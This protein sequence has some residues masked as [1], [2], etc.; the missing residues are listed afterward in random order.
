MPSIEMPDGRIKIAIADTPELAKMLQPGSGATGGEIRL[1]GELEDL[2]GTG[3]L[4]LD[5]LRRRPQYFDGRFLTGA[6]LTRDQDYIR[7]RQADIARAGGSGVISG[8]N[9]DERGSISGDVL[10][11]SAGHGITREGDLVM[12]ATT[13][14]IPLMDL[15]VSRQLDMAMGL[16]IDPRIPLSS[17]S[18]IFVLGLRAIEF[19]AN[20]IAAYPRTL[21]GQARIEDGDII[22]A[23]AVTIIPYPDLNGAATLTDARRSIAR[24]IFGGNGGRGLPQNILPLALLALDRGTVHWIDTAMVRR[25]LTADSGI[26]VSLG[27]RPRSLAEAHVNQHRAHVQD[28]LF[29]LQSRNTA[30]VFPASQFFSLLP[31]AG[32]LPAATVRPEA[33]GLQQVYFPPSVDVD[34]AFVPSDE[35]AA[36]VEESLSLPPID[37]D[38]APEDLDATGIVILLPVNR[39]RYQRFA[40][41]LKGDTSI[42]ASGDASLVRK[43]A[44]VD[45]IDAMRLRQLKKL[46]TTERN[47]E[48]ADNKAD[49]EMRVKAWHD[50]FAEAIDNLPGGNDGAPLLWYV[51]RRSIAYRSNVEGLAIEVSGDDVR[52]VLNVQNRMEVLNLKKALDGIAT[53]ST[54]QASAAVSA[55][56]GSGK[57]AGSN[58]LTAAIV[59]DLGKV[60][61][62]KTEEIVEK[63]EEIKEAEPTSEPS[64]GTGGRTGGGISG[65][66]F[67]PDDIRKRPDLMRE[68]VDIDRLR[69][70][71]RRILA[72]KAA[73]RNTAEREDTKLGLNEAEVRN[74]ASDFTDPKVGEG[75]IAFENVLGKEAPDTKGVTFIAESGLALVIDNAMANTKIEDRK[76]VATEINDAVKKKDSVAIH[77][78]VNRTGRFG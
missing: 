12:L 22:E 11:I 52:T 42:S 32:Q 24:Q 10:T 15:P 63:F 26:Q 40:A 78:I 37:L 38:S 60:S 43:S 46:E 31:P 4:V 16:S 54:P 57:I 8:L 5:G 27:G 67:R 35:I 33:E 68:P 9:L 19:T 14:E 47:E 34:I 13:R 62:G 71:I 61:E 41:L 49:A 69:P 51:R 65:G 25:E 64:D 20:P 30:P 3:T 36:L 76:F 75:L 58:I 73:G 74:I 56:L 18:G 29:E 70:G 50:S 72:E 17:R 21:T 1:R 66:G 53:K 55:L 23:T 6:D 48:L 77:R 7:Q 39:Q 59:H 45:M 28:V 2:L 44:A